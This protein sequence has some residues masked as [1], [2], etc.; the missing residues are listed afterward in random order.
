MVKVQD[1]YTTQDETAQLYNRIRK[2]G[3]II[4][5]R[6][7]N[8]AFARE[9]L[10]AVADQQNYASAAAGEAGVTTGASTTGAA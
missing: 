6:Y 8:S 7:C 4:R 1:P 10:A 5:C 9:G 2:Q 3:Y